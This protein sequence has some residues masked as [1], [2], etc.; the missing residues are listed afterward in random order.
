[1]HSS[2]ARSSFMWYRIHLHYDWFGS[3]SSASVDV[4]YVNWY[5]YIFRHIQ[6]H[7]NNIH[8]HRVLNWFA[9]HKN[10][11]CYCFN[12]LQRFL[13]VD[14]RIGHVVRLM[15][16]ALSSFFSLV[17]PLQTLLGLFLDVTRPLWVWM[18][19]RVLVRT[20][21]FSFVFFLFGSQT[22]FEIWFTH[23]VFYSIYIQ[24]INSI[25]CVCV[26]ES[27]KSNYTNA[28]QNFFVSLSLI[29]Y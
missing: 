4:L 10:V 24:Y 11:C 7:S 22:S 8:I 27:N 28:K 1:M 9:I 13:F 29:G 16:S 5:L 3:I 17:A 14:W 6:L 26:C 12:K 25:D 20:L 2:C 18:F 15:F 19:V 23:S 21:V